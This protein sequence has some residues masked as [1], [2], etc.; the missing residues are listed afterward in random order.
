MN[1]LHENPD[2]DILQPESVYLLPSLQVTHGLT[3]DS[4]LPQ[5]AAEKES[6]LL[7]VTDLK[8]TAQIRGAAI[9]F[10]QSGEQFC[11]AAL[12]GV[13][14][15]YRGFNTKDAELDLAIDTV[16]VDMEGRRIL[17]SSDWADGD[18]GVGTRLPASQTGASQRVFMSTFR[19]YRSLDHETKQ[20]LSFSSCMKGRL[21][22]LTY[23][24]EH[25]DLTR[26]LAYLSDGI[27]DVILRR[28][29]EVGVQRRIDSLLCRYDANN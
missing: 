25:R 28:S 23:I 21:S 26:L 1:V 8:L 27:L 9:Q 3:V 6:H 7:P 24:Y 15:D 2:S 18:K 11:R 10:W 5:F 14:L 29:Y 12:V 22:R 20:P 16:Q 13:T 19:F 4:P 17:S